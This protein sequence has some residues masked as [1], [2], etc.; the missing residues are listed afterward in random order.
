MLGT[1]DYIAPE[2]TLDA[3]KADIRA[4][5]YSLGCTLYHLLTG[6]TPFSGNSL[7]EVLQA[8]HSVEA[9][10]LN[11]VRPEVPVELAAVVA[12]MMA[13]EPN[14][15]YQTPAEVVQ[16][17]KPFLKPGGLTSPQPELSLVA[18]QA[19]RPAAAVA[20]APTPGDDEDPHLAPMEAVQ[21]AERW[22]SL[23]DT[24][25]FD[26]SSAAR[27]AIRKWAPRQPPW[28]WPSLAIGAVLFGLITAW[29]SG[30]F[31]VKTKDGVIVLQDL[32][33]KA[34]VLVDGEK[35]NVSWPGGGS[36]A[37]IT[38]PPGKRGIQVKKDGFQAFG[39]E[40]SLASGEKK[41]L[42]VRLEPLPPKTATTQLEQG[43]TT[44]RPADTDNT[45]AAKS[46]TPELLIA[47]FDKAT[48]EKGQETWAAHLGSTVEITNG[49]GMKMRLIP[50]GR[51]EMGSAETPDELRRAF[52]ADTGAT[53]NPES[54]P[55]GERPVHS[56][57][58]SRPFYL[59]EYEV[60]KGQFKRFV[61]D[62]GYRTDA[63]KDG[64]GG[65][66]YDANK[67]L[68]TWDWHPNFTWRN[69]GVEQADDEP[70]VDV[71]YN[72]ATA[73]CVWLSNKEGKSYRLPTEAEWEYGCRAGTPGRYYNG[74]DPEQLTKI[75]NVSDAT[76]MA[77]L[78]GGPWR[79]W[80]VTSSDGYAFLSPVGKFL[81]N[82]FGLYDMLGNAWEWCADWYDE[83]YYMRSPA[84]D[85]AGPPSGQNR[86]RRGG[87]WTNG[88]A[89]CRA[90]T[91]QSMPPDIRRCNGGFRVA[92]SVAAS[93]TEASEKSVKQDPQPQAT[94]PSEHRQDG[95]VPLFN[96]KD[97]TGWNKVHSETV[98]WTVVNRAIEG[99]NHGGVGSGGAL[100][101]ERAD[102]SDFNLQF[103]AILSEGLNSAV[104]LRRD[105]SVL[106]DGAKRE[107][108]VVIRGTD[109]SLRDQTP[110][111]TGSLQVNL[112]L[113]PSELL[114]AA[115]DRPLNPEEW[116]KV[117]IIAQ[118]QHFRVFIDGANVL[119][120]VDP[121]NVR[122]SGSI[123]FHCRPGSK[124]RFR[125][126]EIEEL[127]ASAPAE[128]ATSDASG[129]SE[130]PAGAS[131]A[132][133]SKNGFV[134]LFNGKDLKGWTNPFGNDS[135]WTVENKTLIGSATNTDDL[136]TKTGMLK[137][138][139]SNY[140]DFRLRMGIRNPDQ[141]NKFLLFRVSDTPDNLT[142]YR[143]DTGGEKFD[144]EIAPLGRYG[145]KT[146]GPWSDAA[147][148]V[149]DGLTALTE[150]TA[151]PLT[152][153]D[154]FHKIEIV[155]KNNEFQMSVDG[156]V[157]SAFRDDESRLKS[158]AIAFMLRPGARVEIRDIELQ[159]L[160][161]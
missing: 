159:D 85:P 59:G 98:E 31:S 155:A 107:Y 30:V 26:R 15:R 66:G 154:Q 23:I 134:S 39:D 118:R 140:R 3:Q 147:K 120:F 88:G 78:P 69:W 97:L 141:I 126:I 143:F 16:A 145:I 35:V 40:V 128:P 131:L 153:G 102:Y 93:S 86:V 74:D 18:S 42:S 9:K 142:Y 130:D 11:L 20:L 161:H 96:G 89:R 106:Q 68:V 12:K 50:P 114:R 47:P 146:G 90:A 119:D 82:N 137:T 51:F 6:S 56:V 1:P 5:I 54:Q 138:S 99:V 38:V 25:Q 72:D 91:R 14:R 158:G 48:A 70:V 84:L 127:S 57:M 29:A 129:Q 21:P 116:F 67:N 32:P 92:L 135:Q 150:P 46:K 133:K 8:H 94:Q 151:D 63:E 156:K 49:I 136:Q 124:V 76:L 43:G 132:A 100:T 103:E 77:K 95:F 149:T 17:L 22:K 19:D 36:P 139:G 24:P 109:P 7:F 115:A 55:L 117:Q 83:D 10:P 108:A 37:Q 80:S 152:A 28:M 75:G 33:D 73:F 81:P 122:S 144:K 27:S 44:P 160:G 64:K 148:F 34:A 52:P 45:T 157:V 71:S 110:H 2:Q 111:P 62:A 65:Q 101:T 13:K 121:M 60:T 87:A 58:I 61:Q 41:L 79:N 112:V 123:G 104:L 125:K 4:D 113:K 53:N 105:T